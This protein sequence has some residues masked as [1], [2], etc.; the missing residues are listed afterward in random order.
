[1]VVMDAPPSSGEDIRPFVA[2]AEHLSALGYSVPRLVA[3]EAE[4]GFLLMEDLGDDLFSSLLADAPDQEPLLYE[5]AVDLLADLAGHAV[6]PGVVPYGPQMPDLAALAGTWYAGAPA[7]ARALVQAMA[8]LT[9]IFDKAPQTLI[10]RDFHAQNLLWL[11][12]RDGLRRVGVL[13][14]Q[15]AQS[16]PV[17]YDLVSLLF[18][19]RRDVAP[20]LIA[21]LQA[22]YAARIG[23]PHAQF[24]TLCAGLLAQRSLRILG[25][26]A[27][28]SLHFGKP[29]YVDLIPRV[30]GHLS[31]ALA[32]PALGALADTVQ[33]VLPPPSDAHLDDL[34]SRCGTIPTR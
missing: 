30:W 32:D 31:I 19:A 4:Q 24:Q 26:F 1:M 33:R 17:G 16:G 5:A 25:V 21:P 6:P 18:D 7:A 2:M 8:A 28:L 34:R 11:P 10:H 9:P 22:R 15:D 29:A 3:A 12:A 23:M 20:G 14:F 13:D 27:R